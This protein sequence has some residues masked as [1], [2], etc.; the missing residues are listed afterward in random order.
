[1]TAVKL[2]ERNQTVRTTWQ[3]TILIAVLVPFIFAGTGCAKRPADTGKA[4]EV[5]VEAPRQ[6]PFRNPPNEKVLFSFEKDAEGWSVPEWTLETEDHVAKAVGVS[7]EHARE[8]ASSLKVEA[9]FP[10]KIWTGSLVEIMENFDFTPYKKV[11]CDIYLP[12]E[13]PEGL[14]AKIILT[15]GPNWR[16]TEMANAIF[17]VPGKWTTVSASLEPGTGDWKMT[18]VDDKF[19]KDVRKFAVRVE[20]N[21]GPVYK[22]PVFIDN[23][24][25]AE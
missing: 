15:V 25:V 22:G 3:G 23:I 24:R 17:L 4:P 11:A 19:R 5:K 6:E 20:S 1:M 2:E 21:K 16:F 14:K 12:K 13:A 8:G 7:K 10:G 18:E 9:A